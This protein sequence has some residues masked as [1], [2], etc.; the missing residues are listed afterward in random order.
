MEQFF[1]DSSRVYDCLNYNQIIWRE[2]QMKPLRAQC[3]DIM[4]N[5]SSSLGN[6]KRRVDKDMYQTQYNLDYKK[7]PTPPL[8]LNLASTDFNALASNR[9][10]CN[11][12]NCLNRGNKE[13]FGDDR[14]NA[15]FS[16][17]INNV[18]EASGGGGGGNDSLLLFMQ[19]IERAKS[20][21]KLFET[22]NRIIKENKQPQKDASAQKTK[23]WPKTSSRLALNKQPTATMVD[24]KKSKNTKKPKQNHCQVAENASQPTKKAIIRNGENNNDDRILSATIKRLSACSLNNSSSLFSHRHNN[25]AYLFDNCCTSTVRESSEQGKKKKTAEKKV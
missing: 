17:P 21:D 25:Y 12:P 19:K 18:K 4:W 5:N 1:N 13:V 15:S 23:R 3:Q 2:K 22:E 7:P 8:S 20:K 10:R 16:I 14:V 24:T 11:C 9:N 6:S